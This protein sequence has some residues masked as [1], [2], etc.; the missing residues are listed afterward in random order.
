MRRCGDIVITMIDIYSNLQ[1]NARR[2]DPQQNYSI[3]NV[4]C[5]MSYMFPKLIAHFSHSF[6]EVH[7]CFFLNMS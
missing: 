2:S 7:V 3:V 1:N 5:A 6:I 4:T